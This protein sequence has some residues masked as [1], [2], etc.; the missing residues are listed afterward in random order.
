MIPSPFLVLVAHVVRDLFWGAGWTHIM[1]GQELRNHLFG[2]VLLEELL[3]VGKICL[4][5]F[6]LQRGV[7]AAFGNL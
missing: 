7:Q 2:I 5:G 1:Q 6:L 3:G 4:G